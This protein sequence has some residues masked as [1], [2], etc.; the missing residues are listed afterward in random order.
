MRPDGSCSGSLAGDPRDMTTVELLATR[1]ETTPDAEFLVWDDD[2]LS[3]AEVWTKALQFA[4][5]VGRC[6]PSRR[7]ATY[8]A[9]CPW[10]VQAVFGTHAAGA[11]HVA[12]NRQHRGSILR[13]ML[14]RSEASILVTD[15]DA[16]AEL[17]L[18]GTAV[19]TVVTVDSLD[20]PAFRRTGLRRMPISEFAGTELCDPVPVAPLEPA[21]VLYT[22]GTTGR[23]KAVLLPHTMLTQGARHVAEAGQFTSTDSLHL[24]AP[25]YHIAGQ[26]DLMLP[27]VVAGGSVVL[28]PRFSLSNFWKEVERHRCTVFF[29]F[30]ST[31]QLLAKTMPAEP[32]GLRVG[33][34]GGIPPELRARFERQ[35]G[36]RFVDAYGMTE[37][38]PIAISGLGSDAP[39]SSC[40]RPTS[41]WSVSI[42]DDDDFPVPA[43]VRGQI[44]ARPRRP[45]VMM[46][47]YEHDEAA[48]L[49][50][51]RDLWWH[52]GDEGYVDPDGYLFVT[53]RLS[54]AIRRRGENV[55]P[56]ELEEIVCQHSGVTACVALGVD[57]AELGDQDVKIVV[58]PDP[59]Y[60]LTPES[61]HGWCRER[62][63]PFMV[64]R[65]IDMRDHLPL[66]E[67][68]KVQLEE[69]RANGTDT[70]DSEEKR[71]T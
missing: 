50:A 62:M 66:T 29:G 57:N 55:S 49:A 46:L 14:G 3:Y 31:L 24:W 4:A 45:G 27:M 18:D 6:G 33:V 30:P 42:V 25:L 61:L 58:V 16:L 36:V 26:L 21:S 41:D 12:I 35:L 39:P 60:R 32:T 22:S 8:L 48:T 13:D 67:T 56:R 54:D 65:F 19:Q 71:S 59:L 38:E 5:A 2:H 34:V 9:N 10:A 17:V 20:A 44:V 53:G 7:V 15:S 40:G 43:G 69:L 11:V 70:W 23:S 51:F 64:P 52:T 47:G 28:L 37:A 63:S 68:G 1:V